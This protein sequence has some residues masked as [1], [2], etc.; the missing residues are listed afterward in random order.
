MRRDRADHAGAMRMRLLDTSDGIVLLGDRAGEIGM[1]VV[2]RGVDH[3]NEH[4][5]AGDSLVHLVELQFA[6]DVLVRAGS[7]GGS[8]R[9][10]ALEQPIGVVRVRDADVL[11][12]E[13][14]HDVAYL[15]AAGEPEVIARA[16]RDPEMLRAYPGQAE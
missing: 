9:V 14:A 6:D 12:L 3:R 7:L 16:A 15:A 8:G 2:D 10:V 4:V 1:F 5:V 11:R 13:D